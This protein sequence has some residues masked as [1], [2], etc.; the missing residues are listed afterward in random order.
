MVLELLL[1]TDRYLELD[2]R[3]NL[4]PGALLRA[5]GVV[6]YY[7]GVLQLEPAAAGDLEIL[8]PGLGPAV[9]VAPTGNLDAHLGEQVAVKGTLTGWQSFGS[10][11][12]RLTLD[13]GSGPATVVVWNNVLQGLDPDLLE[14]G[15]S[16]HVVGVVESYEA[17]TQLVPALPV[18]L[19]R[20]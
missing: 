1:W 20:P 17:S 4:R 9:D 13:D 7:D 11:N 5:W 15:A 16:L 12:L 3:A 2:T 19:S 8:E 14:A 10:G 6:N 18:Y